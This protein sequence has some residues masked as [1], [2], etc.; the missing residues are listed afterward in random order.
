MNFLMVNIHPGI[1]NGLRQPFTI[2]WLGRTFFLTHDEGR[3]TIEW[4]MFIDD[5]SIKRDVE[6]IL[7]NYLTNQ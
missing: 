4:N 2:T 6:E 5:D 3:G 7:K 1:K